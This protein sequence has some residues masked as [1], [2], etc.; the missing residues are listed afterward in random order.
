MAGT[1][2][3]FAFATDRPPLDD[4]DVK[5]SVGTRLL[6]EPATVHVIGSSHYVAAPAH[7]FHEVCSC[8]GVD[9]GGAATYDVSLS[10]AA[11]RTLAFGTDRLRAEVAVEGR[12]L[13]AFPADRDFDV[14][15]RFGPDAH[16]A[17]DVR[18]DGYETYHTYPEHGLTLYT[19][20]TLARTRRPASPSANTPETDQ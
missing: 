2:I 20:T 12:G 17:I 7:G 14:R 8:R 4:L 18:R 11:S 1:T 15:Y 9:A 19:E 16:T 3:T 6:G 13:S 10:R 5:A